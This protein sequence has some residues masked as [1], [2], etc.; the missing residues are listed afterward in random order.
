MGWDTV[1]G[2]G[3]GDLVDGIFKPAVERLGLRADLWQTL[4]VMFA[5]LNSSSQFWSSGKHEDISLKFH[6]RL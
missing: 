4:V 1:Q 5:P 2:Q 6:I 3:F